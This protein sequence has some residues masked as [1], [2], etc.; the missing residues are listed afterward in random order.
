MDPK[1]V[2]ALVS[3]K[4]RTGDGDLSRLSAREIE[5]LGEMAQGRNNAAIAASLFIT[6]RAVEKHINSIFSKL[7]VGM[8]N[9]SHPRVRAVLL[10]LSGEP[11]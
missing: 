5:V 2:E 10:Y 1:V 8:E 3:A 9:E 7:G 11:G 4:S 6:Q